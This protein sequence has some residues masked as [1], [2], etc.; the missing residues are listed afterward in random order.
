M[1]DNDGLPKTL[2]EECYDL[3]T[4]YYEFK[5]TCI[6]SQNTLITYNNEDVP[7]SAAVSDG[8]SPR[9]SDAIEVN[10]EETKFTLDVSLKQEELFDNFGQGM[11]LYMI[12][13][14]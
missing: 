7:T 4:K 13:L 9:V 14:F 1:A 12:C 6:Q 2:C 3:L 5:Q 8:D 11:A 10:Y